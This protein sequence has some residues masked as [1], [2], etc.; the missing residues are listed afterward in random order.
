[1][2]SPLLRLGVFPLPRAPPVTRRPCLSLDRSPLLQRFMLIYLAALPLVLYDSSD[3][4]AVPVT[5]VI[6]FLL[7]GIEVGLHGHGRDQGAV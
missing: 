7:L 1:M 5:A 6:A 3:W 4:A 2:P